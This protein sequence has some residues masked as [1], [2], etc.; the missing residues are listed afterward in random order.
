MSTSAL[1]T[2]LE[3]CDDSPEAVIQRIAPSYQAWMED[4]RGGALSFAESW[5]ARG[6]GFRTTADPT[7]LTDE[8][9]ETSE[10]M[11]TYAVKCT[12]P[13]GRSGTVSFVGFFNDAG[14]ITG[15]GGGTPTFVADEGATASTSIVPKL[16]WRPKE[17]VTIRARIALNG[18]RAHSHY[19][20]V[21]PLPS[22]MER[23]GVPR[24]ARYTA[25]IVCEEKR[26]VL[27]LEK[28]VA[29]VVPASALDSV[30]I[31]HR[32]VLLATKLV[33]A[34]FNVEG[35]GWF[36]TPAVCGTGKWKDAPRLDAELEDLEST[37]TAGG[38]GGAADALKAFLTAK[39][40]GMRG[41]DEPDWMYAR[42]ARQFLNSRVT[43][44]ATRGPALNTGKPIWSCLETR[45][46]HCGNY[47]ATYHQLL[48]LGSVPS[49]ITVGEWISQRGKI[50]CVNEVHLE[51]CGW[52]PVEPNGE[53]GIYDQPAT[54]CTGSG[55]SDVPGFGDNEAMLITGDDRSLADAIRLLPEEGTTCKTAGNPEEA[56]AAYFARFDA[57]GDGVLHPTEAKRMIGSV[58]GIEDGNAA[59]PGCNALL[60][61]AFEAFD[62]DG[63]GSISRGELVAALRGEG[64][65]GAILAPALNRGAR[66]GMSQH[67]VQLRPMGNPDATGASAE[68]ATSGYLTF[69]KACDQGAEA[70]TERF[71]AHFRGW[72]DEQSSGGMAKCAARMVSSGAGLFA[73]ANGATY[74]DV[75]CADES[76]PGWMRTYSVQC[77]GAD[78][79]A[80]RVVLD[81]CFSGGLLSGLGGGAQP[82]F[83]SGGGGDT[84]SATHAFLPGSALP[85]FGH[86]FL[87]T[88]KDCNFASG[89]ARFEEM[90]QSGK[91][92]VTV[93]EDDGKGNPCAAQAAIVDRDDANA[94]A[95]EI[96][97]SCRAWYAKR[98]D[99]PVAYDARMLLAAQANASAVVSGTVPYETGGM[100]V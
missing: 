63:D 23:D 4:G 92:Y 90:K 80:G 25:E 84:P 82:R 12:A 61:R 77:T 59:W 27:G 68:A 54:A 86:H 5:A 51:S 28:F 75:P 65:A 96:E 33:P 49:R 91:Q 29:A 3:A 97:A 44:D 11:R 93:G 22:T 71:T 35:S 69:L 40:F 78:G 99:D 52:I 32:F 72:M 15:S 31:V 64:D 38:G 89:L 70:V 43:Y 42:R 60:N 47:S 100:H 21:T 95:D 14:L 6:A 53:S 9:V 18:H 83:V 50:H 48:S 94:V 16:V 67:I 87:Q 26:D 20:I 37:I 85:R 36:D 73:G 58:L 46:G 7:T 8:K 76:A 74:K 66:V 19:L 62:K 79:R 41:A 30:A 34:T 88:C 24:V 2:F 98:G 10:W 1:L 39:G 81:G 13:D 17:R 55:W 57:A 56:A 45:V